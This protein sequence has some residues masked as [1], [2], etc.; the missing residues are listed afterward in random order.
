MASDRNSDI[1]GRKSSAARQTDFATIRDA[2]YDRRVIAENPHA[3][4]IVCRKRGRENPRRSPRTIAGLSRG[5]RQRERSETTSRFFLDILRPPSVSISLERL[6]TLTVSFAFVR[7]ETSDRAA[8][9]SQAGLFAATRIIVAAENSL[10]RMHNE[11][12]SV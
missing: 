1:H 7:R 8:R 2:N 11:L 9:E 5:R 4:R 3:S 6:S 10:S 12:K